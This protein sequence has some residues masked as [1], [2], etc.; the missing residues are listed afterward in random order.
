MATGKLLKLGG[1]DNSSPKTYQSQGRFRVARNV[2]PTPD[3]NIIPRS[4]VAEVSGQGA[5][6]RY[7]HQYAQYDGKLLSVVSDDLG[8]AYIMKAYLDNTAIPMHIEP[9]G[10]GIFNT[11]NYDVSNSVMT[12]RRNNTVFIQEPYSG[13]LAKY[14]GVEVSSAGVQ[15]PILSCAQYASAGTRY[16]RVIQHCIDFDNNEPVSEYVQ[17]PT[18]STT[19]ITIRTDGGATNIINPANA[20]VNPADIIPPRTPQS[21]YFYGTA[22]YSAPS[23]QYNVSVT[24]TNIVYPYQIGSYVIVRFFYTSAA[25]SGLP[26]DSMGIALRVKSISP[27]VLDASNAKYLSLQREW[28][29]GT[30]GTSTLAALIQWGTRN[31]FTVW[32]SSNSVGNYVYRGSGPAFPHSTTSKTFTVDVSSVSV[33]LFGTYFLF[34]IS[35][36]LG[37][38]YDT[39]SKKLSPNAL[40]P[41]G[42]TGFYGLTTYQGLMIMW[43][44]YLIWYSDP[45]LPDGNFEQLSGSSFL[46][47]GDAEYGKV[48]SVS[49]TQDFLLVCRERKNYFING[50]IATGN[51]RV[52]E[53]SDIELGAWSNNSTICIKDTIIMLNATGVYQISSGG[54]TTALAAK[55]PENFSRYNGYALTE[56]VSFLL[57]GT[58]ILAD[59]TSDIGISVAYDEFRELLVFMRKGAG[60]EG[61]PCLVLCTRTAEFYEWDG[62]IS[63]N[64]MYLSAITFMGA[65][66]YAG[67]F[68]ATAGT[69]GAKTYVED[70]SATL[71][72][73]ELYPIKLYSTWM[74]ASEPSLEKEVLQLKIFG[75][76]F[77]NGANA[78]KVVH[79]KDWDISAKITNAD[80]MPDSSAQFSHKKRLNSDKAL[81]VSCGIEIPYTNVRMQLESLEIEFNPIQQ[82]IKR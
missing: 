63:G 26:E 27:L 32:A 18:A 65:K 31:F 50:N 70:Y 13:L 40:Y 2:L 28:K 68:F 47:V 62:I 75:Q 73:P 53:I 3:N 39:Q 11:Q 49:G 51:Y 42:N 34:S 72:Y 52:Q 7:I 36:N 5:T 64:D 79:F 14:D 37:D 10:D 57:D 22:T 15:Q 58:N 55:I 23:L 54:Q 17:F 81:A 59:T 48:I 60:F 56:D 21:P 6:K 82:G 77:D 45:S 67:M 20:N 76:I 8:G 43:T 80:Y 35:S 30:A 33:S 4:E 46:L 69:L 25:D 24:D 41:Y 71:L 78:I 44:D 1:M 66:L 61:N 12:Y 74:T 29:T 19:T 38:W 9:M 16:V